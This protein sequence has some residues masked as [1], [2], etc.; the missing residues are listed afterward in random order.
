MG[1][2]SYECKAC[3]HSVLSP[4]S[5][6]PEINGW[7]KDAV[8][9][10]ANGTRLICEFDGYSGE[11]DEEVGYDA[12]WLH[13]ACWEVAGRP[14]YD[15]FDGPS[16]PARDQGF[17]FGR[18]HDMIDP[19][20]TDEAE[21]ERLLAEGIETRE[22]RWYDDRARTVF[23]WLDPEE[24]RYHSEDKQ[25]EPWRNRYSY[26]QTL[27]RDEHGEVVREDGNAVPDPEGW[28][29]TDAL[30]P[31]APDERCGF[32][33]TEDALKAELASRWAAFVESEEAAAYMRR[34]RELRAEALREEIE[35]LKKTGR[36]EVSHT[37]AQGDIVEHENDRPWVGSRSIHLV[38]DLLLYEDVAKFD[39]PNEALGRQTFQGEYPEE[40]IE[41]MRASMR[42]SRRLASEECQRLNDEWA[43]AGYPLPE[44]WLEE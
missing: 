4:H 24:R 19:R 42:E 35:T 32:R 22:R 40:R 28:H 23:E 11:Y 27:V 30:D 26:F 36:Y 18:D 13:Q 8:I 12:V 44:G 15:G 39:G 3:G 29:I 5:V 33:G 9:L 31:E 6:D 34:R 43:A 16:R 21:R 1:F 20:I 37:P 14:A 7:M 38:R 17:F 25:A 2:S 10:G 41:A